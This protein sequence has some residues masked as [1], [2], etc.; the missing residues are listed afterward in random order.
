MLDFKFWSEKFI[1]LKQGGTPSGKAPHKPLLLL[2]LI[3]LVDDFNLMENKVPLDIRL[4]ELFEFNWSL[5]ITT[6]NKCDITLPIFHL[7]NEQFWKVFNKDNSQVDKKP[8]S[9]NQILK[10]IRFGK[11]DDRLWELL[12]Q[13]V[14]RPLFRMVLLDYYF[15]NSK[16]KYLNNRPSPNYIQ[17]L[18]ISV[19]EEGETKHRTILKREEGYVRD[20]KFR[21]TVLRAYNFTCCISKLNFDP[22]LP[23]IEAC[24]IQPFADF[25]NNHITNGI[26]LC[27]NLH[28]AFDSGILSLNNEFEVLVKGKNEFKE[29][30]NSPYNIRQFEGSKIILPTNLSFYPN[31]ENL[32]W[33]RLFHR[34]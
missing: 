18:E 16:D 26:P 13:P 30:L 15:P 2:A 8:S 12:T 7:Q 33:H 31:L 29:Q 9:Q 24:H 32:K 3:D 20:W 6:N 17:E 19:L 4:F 5:L 25:G 14:M 22:P 23:I 11:F 34:F 27:T 28:R 1:S 21:H 10:K